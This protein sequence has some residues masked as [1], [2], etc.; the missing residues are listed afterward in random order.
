MR[1]VYYMGI[2]PGRWTLG[3]CFLSGRVPAH[4]YQRTIPPKDRPRIDETEQAHHFIEKVREF[5]AAVKPTAIGIEIVEPQVWVAQGRIPKG[6]SRLSSVV[7]RMSL[8][9]TDDGFTVYPQSPGIQAGYPDAVVES[10]LRRPLGPD[11][12]ITPHLISATKHA[13]HAAAHYE[14]AKA[15]R[16]PS[17]NSDNL[18]SAHP[19]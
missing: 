2:D 7:N 9:L 5:A 12:A 4:I 16:R 3:V 11:L 6:L 13:L 18:T 10:L 14:Q 17:G 8:A 1:P 19:G 15:T